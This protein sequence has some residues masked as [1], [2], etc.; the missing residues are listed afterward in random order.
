MYDLTVKYRLLFHV[1]ADT[2]IGIMKIRFLHSVSAFVESGS[3]RIIDELWR[4]FSQ[5]DSLCSYSKHR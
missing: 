2:Q 3:I 5:T 4:T 1:P